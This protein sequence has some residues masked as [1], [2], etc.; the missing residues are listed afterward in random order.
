MSGFYLTIATLKT[1]FEAAE[2]SVRMFESILGSNETSKALASIITLVRGELTQDPRFTPT[3][4]GAIAS[5]TALTKALTAYVCLQTATH[6]RTLKEMRLKVVYDCTIVLED[7]SSP[8]D[9]SLADYGRRLDEGFGERDATSTLG[10]P[11][12]RTPSMAVDAIMTDVRSEYEANGGRIPRT[13]QNSIDEEAE[14]VTELETLCGS[15]DGDDEGHDEDEELPESVRAALREVGVDG[16]SATNRVVRAPESDYDYEIETEETT[17]KTTTIIRAL[18]SSEPDSAPRTISRKTKLRPESQIRELE[19]GEETVEDGSEDEW[20][21]LSTVIAN[22]GSLNE[23]D[24][25]S[26]LS[27]LPSSQNGSRPVA[28]LSRHDTIEHPAESKERFHFVIEK[29]TKTLTQ[30][31]RTIRRVDLP[32]RSNSPAAG[33]RAGKARKRESRSSHLQEYR[34]DSDDGDDTAREELND[35]SRSPKSKNAGTNIIRA[36]GT[37]GRAI[38][39]TASGENT[40]LGRMSR[41]SSSGSIDTITPPATPQ[42][43]PSSPS[44]SPDL[45]PPS[46]STIPSTPPKV[47]N[48]L[49]PTTPS[50]PATPPTFAAG[51]P[52]DRQRNLGPPP[53]SPLRSTK[54]PIAN[55]PARMRRATSNESMRSVTTT[56]THV[57]EGPEVEESEPKAS[58]FPREH[59]VKNLLTFMRYSSAAYGQTFLRILGMG[60]GDFN[61]PHTETHANNHAF[62]HHVGIKVDDVLLSSYSD[63]PPFLGDTKISPL[64]NFIA[65]DHKMKAIVLSCRGSL[66]LSDLLVDLTCSY[67]P[68]PLR[69][70][71]PGAAYY[72]HSGMYCSATTMQRGTV[73]E[74]IRLALERYPN[75][76]LVLCG[77]SLGGGVA[78]LLAILWSIPSS[79]YNREMGFRRNRWSTITTPTP[80]TAF[81]TGF[82]SGFPAG[83]PIICYSYGPPCTTSPDLM[84][85]CHGLVISTIH[86]FDIVPTLSL[87]VVRDLKS[88]AMAMYTDSGTVEEIVGRVIG[89][90]QRRFMGKAGKAKK[91][92]TDSD[93]MDPK[94]PLT[95]MPDEALEVPLS[96]GELDAGRGNNRAL[97]PKYRDPS[98][99]GPDV[100]EDTDLNDWMWSL[101]KTVRAGHDAE[102][103]YPPGVV[104]IIESWT[105]FVFCESESADWRKPSRQTRREGR[106]VILRHVEDVEARFSEPIFGRTMMSDHSPSA[107]EEQLENLALAMA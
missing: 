5:L 93:D 66:G 79:A 12:E 84:R 23:E 91:E 54:P 36:F 56:V 99:L 53:A 65:V 17:T 105:V 8:R 72:A 57:T 34:P 80:M 92:R 107:Y 26:S 27:E 15:E 88:T 77:H 71:D 14:I 33:F 9:F 104:Y 19:P 73:H 28:V 45:S 100:S 49:K 70:G 62:A 50:V 1:G 24:M 76:G 98:L 68:V 6:K 82:D 39:R 74:T 95:Q 41:A 42:K 101:V 64:V 4:R 51:P 87:G 90:Y 31:K 83:R 22:D 97:D 60:K 102:K 35:P 40:P 10:R 55:R 11:R 37:F 30:R 2:E 25:F 43:T 78:A 63:T 48:P 86:N 59:L 89:L 75:Y 52:L 3:E 44:I 103:L 18:T 85:Y 20:V 69:Y 61:F 13:R 32:S 47:S 96:Q 67:E 58:N 106:R 94:A 21:E 7:V 46:I 38:K 81:V 16:P 29:L